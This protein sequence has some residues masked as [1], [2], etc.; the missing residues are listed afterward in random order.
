MKLN[1]HTPVLLVFGDGA[2]ARSLDE[3]IGY[4]LHDDAR[5]CKEEEE[6]HADMLGLSHHVMMP[7]K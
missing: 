3:V 1:L 7:L 4:G 2:S 6:T 5:G